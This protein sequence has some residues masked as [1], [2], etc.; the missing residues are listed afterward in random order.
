MYVHDEGIDTS[1][2]CHLFNFSSLSV[3]LG[4]S[5]YLVASF[6]Y[7]VIGKIGFLKGTRVT[8]SPGLA[9]VCVERAV[10]TTR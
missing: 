10:I 9:L 4:F 2:S 8:A 1:Y 6:S 3:L 5:F 7:F